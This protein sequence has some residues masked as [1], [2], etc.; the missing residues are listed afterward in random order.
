MK[1]SLF[2]SLTGRF[3]DGTPLETLGNRAR[4]INSVMD[5]LSR[6]F[7]TRLGSISHVPDYGLPDISEIYRDMPHGLERLQKAI[8]DTVVRYEPRLVNPVIRYRES[9]TDTARL[10]FIISG[11][12]RGGGPVQFKTSFTGTGNSLISAIRNRNGEHE[13]R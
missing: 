12:I 5:H 6:M 4:H 11:E 3:L 8:R 2:E 7:N 13:Q 10:I 1:Q 9:Q